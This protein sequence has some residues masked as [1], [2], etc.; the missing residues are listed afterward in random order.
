L[1]SRDRRLP[2][3]SS[4][5]AT[6]PSGRGPRAGSPRRRIA[7]A[8]FG[9]AKGRDRLPELVDR[10]LAGDLDLDSLVTRRI[11]LDE[12]NEA[13]A[14]MERQEGIRTVITY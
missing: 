1:G 11:E 4:K 9:G 3:G 14:V 10:Y 2:A 7:G 6:V 8:S 13:F 5:W 12:V